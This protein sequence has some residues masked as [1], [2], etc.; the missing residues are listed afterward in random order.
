MIK[1][2]KQLTA[3][4]VK[5]ALCDQ[6]SK[7]PFETSKWASSEGVDFPPLLALLCIGPFVRGRVRTFGFTND[8][9]T[10]I[11]KVDFATNIAS[12]CSRPRYPRV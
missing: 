12:G 2:I 9:K 11:S 10:A 6:L 1:V 5:L 3:E 8:R 7:F 4:F